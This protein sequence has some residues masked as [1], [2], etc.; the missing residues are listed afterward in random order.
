M[1]R[2][3]IC[4]LCRRSAPVPKWHQAYAAVRSGG[5]APSAPYICP[6]CA[7]RLRAEAMEQADLVRRRG[8]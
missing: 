2:E 5:T 4:Q 6:R 7:D 1:P 8:R 3:L